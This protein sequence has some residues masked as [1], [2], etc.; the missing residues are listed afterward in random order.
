MH[1][2]NATMIFKYGVETAASKSTI[3]DTVSRTYAFDIKQTVGP[4]S[5][6]TTTPTTNLHPTRLQLPQPFPFK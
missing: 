5:S 4:H 3:S 6:T 2:A 1:L